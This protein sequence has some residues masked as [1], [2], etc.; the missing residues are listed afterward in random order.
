MTGEV[1]EDDTGFDP[2]GGR[3]GGEVQRDWR[4][5]GRRI[6]SEHALKHR[7]FSVCV[8]Q[9]GQGGAP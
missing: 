1:G 5:T 7:R 3:F 2:A 8:H 6:G 4:V 9:T